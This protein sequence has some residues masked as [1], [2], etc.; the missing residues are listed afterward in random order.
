MHK[1]QLIN[2]KDDKKIGMGYIE[3]KNPV[4]DGN[5]IDLQRK[6]DYNDEGGTDIFEVIKIVHSNNGSD[7]YIKH[8]GDFFIS[9]KTLAQKES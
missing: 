3:L 6:N 4:Q 7:L 1:Y 5:W 9:I 8:I 2:V